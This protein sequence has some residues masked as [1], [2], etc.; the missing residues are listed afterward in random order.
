MGQSYSSQLNQQNTKYS[1]N[2]NKTN[3]QMTDDI[4]R[5]FKSQNTTRLDTVE[6]E[7]S[8]K[9]MSTSTVEVDTI[10]NGIKG[11][12]NSRVSVVPSR[13]RY[14]DDNAKTYH[15]GGS[16]SNNNDN[17]KD[18][19][20]ENK[21][22]L[23]SEDIRYVRNIVY[24]NQMRGG[25]NDNGENNYHIFNK[26]GGTNEN[27]FSRESDA[28]NTTD[29]V[30]I[31]NSEKNKEES[32]RATET[33]QNEMKNAVT[34]VNEPQKEEN[35]I[36]DVVANPLE[37]E[38]KVDNTIPV[39]NLDTN[40]EP[41]N[42]MPE[43]SLER[44]EVQVQV[45]KEITTRDEKLEPNKGTEE[46][47]QNQN[48][49]E[50]R[51]GEQNK[52]MEDSVAGLG[53][54]LGGAARTNENSIDKEIKMIRKFIDNTVKHR[55]GDGTENNSQLNATTLNHDKNGEFDVLSEDGLAEIRASLAKHGAIPQSEL[56]AN[57]QKGGQFDEDL[58]IFRDNILNQN[59]QPTNDIYSVTSPDPVNYL[60]M[61]KGGAKK[62]T[63]EKEEN[64]NKKTNK[65]LKN[66][67]KN[68]DDDDDDDDDDDE[69]EDDDEEDDD[70]E[71]EDD[72][73][74]DDDD[75]GE[76]EAAGDLEGGRKNNKKSQR[77]KNSSSTS[78][79]TSCSS[80]DSSSDSDEP[81]NVTQEAIN[82]NMDKRNNKSRYLKNNNYKVTSNSDRDY[83]INNKLVYSSQ[84]SDAYNSVGSE[85]LNNMRNRDRMA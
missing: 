78:S 73:D 15:A 61:L 52:G 83:K 34:S 59:D 17:E 35:K 12:N 57:K 55:G 21:N 45:P 22:M 48:Q 54:N 3:A 2:V 24:Q 36:L 62:E 39:N 46:Q 26:T 8:N 64:E 6:I 49:N 51:E 81:V 7:R 23:D 68:E 33:N 41:K 11:G 79:T 31:I 66:K 80:S 40:M 16:C 70:E 38:P 53:G 63:D 60:E 50:N 25:I 44:N 82:K 32:N 13:Q 30:E 77:E 58:K 84:T 10:I 37:L 74:D 69:D 65:K 85:Y 20:N 5:L 29:N 9:A 43:V 71:E 76:E 4:E 75:E 56:Q 18:N 1:G 19:D 27:T 72:E 14:K 28:E 42:E 47:S 67:N